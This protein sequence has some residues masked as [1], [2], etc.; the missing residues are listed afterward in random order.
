[1]IVLSKEEIAELTAEQDT[2]RSMLKG[3]MFIDMDIMDKIHNIQM[4][5]D[6][7]KPG[8]SYVEC[9]GCGS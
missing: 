6:G 4:K 8:D 7:I 5:L 3:D 9:I 2:L 1:M